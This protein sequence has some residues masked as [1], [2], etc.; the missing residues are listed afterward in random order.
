VKAW[1]PFSVHPLNG[2]FSVSVLV[3]FF[4]LNVWYFREDIL[5]RAKALQ[6]KQRSGQ[7]APPTPTLR[8]SSVSST[9]TVPDFTPV[10]PARRQGVSS[11]QPKLSAPSFLAPTTQRLPP[12]LLAPRYSHLLEEAKSL[13][14]QD[15]LGPRTPSEPPAPS[16]LTTDDRP[17]D[18]VISHMKQEESEQE[19]PLSPSV[20][21]RVKGFLF[22]YL[23]TLKT[24]TPAQKKTHQPAC[25]GLPLPPPELLEKPRGPIITP[26]PKPA[27]RPTHPKELIHLQ[28]APTPSLIPTLPRIPKRLVDLRPVSPP[29]PVASAP[30]QIPEGR[31]SSGGSVKDLVS[32]FED[33]ERSR[34]IEAHAL[35]IRR[36]KSAARLAAEARNATMTTTTRTSSGRPAWK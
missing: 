2:K 35:E 13:S 17:V 36:K 28:H 33:M 19:I 16:T 24:K 27:P 32:S 8:F 23:P 29:P 18:N 26:Q 7:G 11:L 12:S 34:E 21:K 4:R 20:G 15:S 30:I 22:S 6:K 10:H 1:S 31:R 5:K 3:S 9:P 14:K 25:P